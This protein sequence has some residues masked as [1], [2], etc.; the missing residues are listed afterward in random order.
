MEI[1]AEHRPVV[2]TPPKV[3]L[4]LLAGNIKGIVAMVFAVASFAGMD[5]LLK[6]FSTHYSPMQVTAMRG[7]ASLPFMLITIALM[8]RLRELRPVRW[9]LHLLRGVIGVAMLGSFIWGLKR[10]SMADAYTMYLSAPLMIAALSVPFL[11]ERIGWRRCVAIV[12]G[13]LGV[14]IM[15]KPEASGFL[16]VGAL[17]VLLSAVIYSFAAIIV[18]VLARTD[19]AI[20]TI[21]WQLVLM[22]TGAGVI[23][24]W[25]WQPIH[26]EHFGWLIGVG[27]FGAIGQAFITVAFRA[28]PPSIVA[29][30]EYTALLWGVLI[31]WTI[32]SVLPSGRVYIGAS[33]VIASGLYLIWR[34]RLA[35]RAELTTH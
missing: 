18:R 2:D 20:S 31:D 9:E 13:L 16:N 29:P 26:Q 3:R 25:N 8:G 22:M 11:G 4:P 10:L 17:A 19:T 14:I 6:L 35:H 15:L 30:F 33:V 32:W 12:V 24:V 34:E 7:A 23:A 27:V 28:A 1:D 5:S 21:F